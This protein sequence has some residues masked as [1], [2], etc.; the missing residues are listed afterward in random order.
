ML[1]KSKQREAIL[2]VLKSTTVHP[3][4][5]WILEQVKKE[6]PNISY[7]TVYRNLRLLRKT[8]D[9]LELDLAG[10]PSHFTHN[11]QD[12]YHFRCDKCDR[13]FDLETPVYR[14]INDEVKK[15]TGFN[16]THHVLEFRGLCGDCQEEVL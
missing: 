13:V 6:I 10:R 4:A 15:N 7:V 12:H 1:H 3:T 8:G 2:R 11:V 5:D 16:A 14:T 9:I